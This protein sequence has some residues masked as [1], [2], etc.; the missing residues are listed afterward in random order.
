MFTEAGATTENY[1]EGVYVNWRGGFTV[2]VNFSSDDYPVNLPSNAKIIFGDKTLKPA[3]V[4]V[5][6]E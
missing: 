5:W 2:A 1:P 4:L 3:G 6:M